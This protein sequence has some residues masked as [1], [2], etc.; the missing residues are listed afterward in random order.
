MKSKAVCVF[1]I[2]FCV[3]TIYNTPVE[4]KTRRYFIAAVEKK[5]DYAPSGYN[6]VKGVR[7]EDDR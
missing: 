5:W 4:S 6:K 2:Q 1:L 7:L 3:I